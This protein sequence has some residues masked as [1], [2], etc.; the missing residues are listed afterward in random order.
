[1]DVPNVPYGTSAN[2]SNES[3]RYRQSEELIKALFFW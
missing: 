2:A 1:M 3:E